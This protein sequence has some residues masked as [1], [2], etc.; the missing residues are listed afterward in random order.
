MFAKNIPINKQIRHV[1]LTG[2]DGAPDVADA[3]RN[4]AINLAGVIG[5]GLLL[6]RDLT[7]QTKDRRTVERE[8]AFARLQV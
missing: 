8:E 3:A 1:I 5:L 4:T 7:S 2:G 6:R